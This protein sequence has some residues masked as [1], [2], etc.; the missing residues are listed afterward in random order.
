MS[1]V[2]Q[3]ESTRAREAAARF[4]ERY[5]SR[6]AEGGGLE[7]YREGL[8]VLTDA[9][10]DALVERD[11]EIE[12]LRGDLFRFLEESTTLH[13]EADAQRTR[14]EQ[15]EAKLVDL[16]TRLNVVGSARRGEKVIYENDVAALRQQ[17]AA[18]KVCEQNEKPIQQNES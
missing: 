5:R 2:T 13:T 18:P 15:A 4:V 8:Q 11:A 10:T 12:R 7:A 14:A 1:D 3:D 9:I 17:L 16:S 6:V